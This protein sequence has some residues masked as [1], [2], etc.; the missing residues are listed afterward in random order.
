MTK[1]DN[2]EKFIEM[3]G[4]ALKLY[5]REPVEKLTYV[6]EN[7]KEFVEIT[8]TNGYKKYADISHD[9]C[10]TVMRDVFQEM[11]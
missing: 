9:S 10:I 5:S 2:K 7:S 3:L 6:R 4:E 1:E 11:V 8:Y